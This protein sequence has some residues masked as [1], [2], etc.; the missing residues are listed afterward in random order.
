MMSCSAQPTSPT[1][2]FV[3]FFYGTHPP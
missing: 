3:T 2:N 1:S